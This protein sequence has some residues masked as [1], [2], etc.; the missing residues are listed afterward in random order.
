MDLSEFLGVWGERK[1]LVGTV[2]QDIGRLGQQTE[3]GK[4]R[5]EARTSDNTSAAELAAYKKA[6]AH[7]ETSLELAKA[8]NEYQARQ[9]ATAMK[10]FRKIDADGSGELDLEE[11]MAGASILSLSQVS[12]NAL[13][14]C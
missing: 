2:A 12:I 1:L 11:V 5:N 8:N 4:R 6:H 13:R 14:L 9:N 3:A 10:K 7:E